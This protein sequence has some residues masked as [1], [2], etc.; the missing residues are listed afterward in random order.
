MRHYGHYDFSGYDNLWG[1]TDILDTDLE[2]QEFDSNF[3]ADSNVYNS[4]L[5][6]E[7][8]RLLNFPE[9]EQDALYPYDEDEEN[10]DTNADDDNDAFNDRDTYRD[11]DV[12][13]AYYLI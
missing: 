12:D 1:H 3:N 10:I 8:S 2:Q 13:D 5:D 4:I 11:R 6:D 9:E 7:P